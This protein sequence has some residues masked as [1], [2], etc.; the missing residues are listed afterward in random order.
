MKRAL[1]AMSG[2][3]DSAAAAALTLDAGYE[4]V[5]VTMRLIPGGGGKCC[6]LQDIND[7]RAAARKLGIPHYV[8]NYTAAF[9][10]AVIEPFAAAYEAGLTPNPCIECNRRIKFDLLLR[11]AAELEAECLVTGHYA[12]IES[13]GGGLRLLKGIDPAKDQSYVLYMLTQKELARLRF[14]L[15]G[16]TKAAAREIAA[17]RGL[18][19]ARKSE[20]QDIC[21]VEDGDYGGFIETWRGRAAERGSIVDTEGKVLGRHRG[22]IRYTL[23]QRRGT[24]VSANE[25]RYVVARDFASNTLVLGAEAALYSS[26]M[27]VNGISFVSGGGAAAAR[28]G[29]KTRYLQK[30]A[31]ARVER[32][33]PD[34][35]RVEFDRPQRAL[36]PGQAA[37]FYDGDEVIGGGT[38][39]TAL[40]Q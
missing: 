33:G 35:L 36:T 11:R 6:S 10:R 22:L 7:A 39:R 24:V 16:I 14:P 3:V 20:S 12:R 32:T 29:V 21:F 19:N 28:W 31:P 38:I 8:L 30:E 26:A 18:A 40:S 9:S 37:V 34:T 1:V 23:G 27:I 13:G 17:S 4:C 5:G 2:G 15:G 25:R